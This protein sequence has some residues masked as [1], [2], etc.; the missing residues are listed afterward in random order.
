MSKDRKYLKKI[1]KKLKGDTIK[2]KYVFLKSSF[3]N[4]ESV[5]DTNMLLVDRITG[6]MS[7]NIVI[8][9]ISNGI[10][11]ITSNKEYDWDFIR[12]IIGDDFSIEL[13][14]IYNDRIEVNYSGT[15]DD[16]LNIVLN[17]L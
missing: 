17:L 2:D 16:L 4:Y 8:E 11:K 12:V 15:N 10:F 3:E 9:K 13:A 1:L 5:I 14:F 7:N 6:L